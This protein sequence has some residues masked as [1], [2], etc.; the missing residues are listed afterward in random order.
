[1]GIIKRY[2]KNLRTH[3][4]TNRLR[5]VL[6]LLLSGIAFTAGGF[7]ID[8]FIPHGYLMNLSRSVVVLVAGLSFSSLIYAH[9]E[10]RIAKKKS[11][12]ETFVSLKDLFSPTQRRNISIIFLVV[13]VTVHFLAVSPR[14][15]FYS[16]SSVILIVLF[17]LL[18]PFNLKTLQEIKNTELGIKDIRDVASEESRETR[19]REKEEKKKK[20]ARSKSD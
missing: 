20:K 9:N 2:L 13:L 1:M 15:Y 10:N 14:S 16:I 18:V 19:I 3:Y 17:L 12:N 7:L 8:Y 6:I 11:D 4:N 5:F